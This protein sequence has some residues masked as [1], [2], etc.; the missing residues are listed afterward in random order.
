MGKLSSFLGGPQSR[1]RRD[2]ARGLLV[3]LLLASAML[4]ISARSLHLQM[5][6]L[7]VADS[8]N[9]GWL[10]SQLDVDYKALSIALSTYLIDSYRERPAGAPVTTFA[11][12]MRRFDIFYSRIDT[13][14]AGL[15]QGEVPPELLEAIDRLRR[16]RDELAVR[17]DAMDQPDRAQVVAI[18]D[19]LVAQAA[20]V[21]DVTTSS[22]HFFVNAAME[23]RIQEQR[24][25]R[26]F[27]LLT[28]LLLG[29]TGIASLVAFYLWRGVVD[30]ATQLQRASETL[31][32]AFRAALSAVVV[33]DM[34]GRILMV[35]SAAGEMFRMPEKDMLGRNVADVM[36]PDHLRSAHEISMKKFVETG[37]RKIVGAGPVRLDA[38][39]SDGSGFRAELSIN[40]DTDLDGNP[41]LIGFISDVSQNEAAEKKLETARDEAQRLAEAKTMFLATMSH[42]MRTPLH[43]VIAALDL[44]D[45]KALTAKDL[46]LVQ[47]A[48]N[49]SERALRQIND[50]LDITRL[51]EGSEDITPYQPVEISRDIVSE[52]TPLA[53]EKST[54]LRLHVSGQ[55][56]GDLYLGSPNA[57]SRAIY[58][59]VGNAVKYTTK[60][61]VD[62]FL[63][64]GGSGADGHRLSVCVK[65]DGPGIAPEDV[66]RIF[67]AFETG[68]PTSLK[69]PEGTGLGLPIARMAVQR[70][71]GTLSVSS[72]P[73]HGSEFYFDIPLEDA[74]V[75]AEPEVGAAKQA[76][77]QE[78]M[79]DVLVVDD[80]SVNV[81][82]MRETIVRLG[83]R[84]TTARDGREAVNAAAEHA[85]DVILMDINMPVMNGIDAS[86]RIREGG[87]SRKAHI[88]AVTAISEPERKAEIFAAGLN[89][90]LVKPT[91]LAD[92]AAL[93]ASLGTA[94]AAGPQVHPSETIA[95]A[96]APEAL[97]EA[98]EALIG[99]AK[100]IDLIRNAVAEIPEDL[101]TDAP[102]LS[103]SEPLIDQLHKAAGVT[104][105]VGFATLS[106]ELSR[107]ERAAARGDTARL[108]EC[109]RRIAE[110]VRA[111]APDLKR[112]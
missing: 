108:A 22:L 4:A 93:L 71:G 9:T 65:D 82:L 84:A 43:G 57:F 68:A 106:R 12:V 16:M 55:G 7:S 33:T 62:L 102:C 112:L 74:P 79:L 69:G 83:H 45:G 47:I 3:C 28:L 56:T 100:A 41:I 51:G 58:N 73:G 1:V 97:V 101:L 76:P 38:K 67:R 50:V 54:E 35:N 105:T 6:T 40:T 81:D 18:S 17:L 42:E 59:L 19:D 11:D 87:L 99:R 63:D 66:K 10:V 14:A 61:H 26:R 53:T 15:T 23:A 103:V 89:S 36:V 25:L 37:E 90:I 24:Y 31:F 94:E 39:R 110:L 88:V 21:R 92:V 72:T 91:R 111:Y 77:S 27:L 44:I 96:E 48:Q 34:D 32:K 8:D 85:F 49:C 46:D 86:R 98:L 5:N 20:L 80:A 30:H 2:V 95:A 13:V 78:E 104:G 109:G 52:L 70:L 29:V 64:F 107:A 60:G 75:P